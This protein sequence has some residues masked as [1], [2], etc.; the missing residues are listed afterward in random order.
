[1]HGIRAVLNLGH[2]PDEMARVTEMQRRELLPLLR[3]RLRGDERL[4]LDFGC[5]PGRFTGDLADITRAR[6][7]GIDPIPRLLELAPRHPSVEYR[8]MSEGHIPLDSSSVD[9]VWICL[10]LGGIHGSTLGDTIAE[11]RRVLRPGGLVFLVENTNEGGGDSF[12][13]FRSVAD[14]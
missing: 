13:A 3:S 6:V 4:A 1:M 7:V 12:W 11:V 5:G 9:L 2:G 10:V 14:Y 8:V